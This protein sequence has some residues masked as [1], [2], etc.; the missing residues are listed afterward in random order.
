MGLCAC[1]W[2]LTLEVSSMGAWGAT[3]G[4]VKLLLPPRQSRGISFASLALS[5]SEPDQ[6]KAEGYLSRA[7]AIARKAVHTKSWKLRTAIGMARLWRDQGKSQ[8]ALDLRAPIYGWFTEGLSTL[9]LKN[10]K[11]LPDQLT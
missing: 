10:A 5:S 11:A 7:F 2:R 1:V 3:A 4:N 9:D 6:T 8:R